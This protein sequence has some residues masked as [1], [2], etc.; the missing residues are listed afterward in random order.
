MGI[1]ASNHW[2]GNIFVQMIKVV[3]NSA[4]EVP[5]ERQMLQC[6][7]AVIGT[8]PLVPSRSPFGRFLPRLGP[9]QATVAAIF[10]WGMIPKSVKRFS[11]KIMRK[12]RAKAG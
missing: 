2:K 7:I 1:L 12:Q 9:L 8:E 4:S 3:T 10:L 6:H 5:L 11:E